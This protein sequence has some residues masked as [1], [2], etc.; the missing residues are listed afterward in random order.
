[1]QNVQVWKKFGT[2]IRKKR[3]ERGVSLRAFSTMIEI[4]PEYLSKIE[5]NLRAAPKDIVGE[6]RADVLIWNNEERETLFDLA[7]ESK[8]CLSLA[9][10]LVK[11]VKDNKM[12]YKALRFA[13]RKELT[14]ID[15]QEILEYI[16]K[17]YL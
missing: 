14:D 17:T 1:M 5:N 6:R 2:F 3:I 9:S 11:Y 16:T 15:W 8:P 7:A 10:D 12:V 13:K 4:S